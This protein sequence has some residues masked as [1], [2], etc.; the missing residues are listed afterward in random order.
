[1]LLAYL[2]LFRPMSYDKSSFELFLLESSEAS[3]K[4]EFKERLLNIIFR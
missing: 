3:L 1:M 4:F 2:L